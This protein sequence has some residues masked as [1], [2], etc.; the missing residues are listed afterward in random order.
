M[1]NIAT[2]PDTTRRLDTSIDTASFSPQRWLANAHVQSILPSL[3]LRKP[4]LNRRARDLLTVSVDHILDCGEGV[5]LLGHY[6]SQQ[7]AGRAPAKNLAILLHGWE[8]SAESLYVLSLGSYLF[9]RGCDVFR[10]NFR[11]H[12]PSHHLNEDIFHVAGSARAR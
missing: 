2:T 5:R 10:L 9:Q 3:K 1:T 11:D 7:A 8:G 12:G 6:S 4:W